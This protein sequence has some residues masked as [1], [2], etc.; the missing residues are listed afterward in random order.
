MSRPVSPYKQ[1]RDAFNVRGVPGAD[2]TDRRIPTS[3]VISKDRDGTDTDLTFSIPENVGTYTLGKFYFFI[4]PYPGPNNQ[5]AAQLLAQVGPTGLLQRFHLANLQLHA[6]ALPQPYWSA[7]FTHSGTGEDH[8]TNPTIE[9]DIE[10]SSVGSANYQ[11]AEQSQGIVVNVLDVAEA[12][13]RQARPAPIVL[14]SQDRTAQ[15]IDWGDAFADPEGWNL[16]VQPRSSQY[17][18][19]SDFDAAAHTFS[20]AATG[21]EPTSDYVDEYLT[22]SATDAATGAAAAEMWQG[23]SGTAPYVRTYRGGRRVSISIARTLPA[24]A[25]YDAASNTVTIPL[26]PTADGSQAGKA[27]DLGAYAASASR[28]IGASLSRSLSQTGLNGQPNTHYEQ[29][30]HWGAPGAPSR[31][32]GT[33][34]PIPAGDTIDLTLT[35]SSPAVNPDTPTGSLAA[36]ASLNIRL[37][38]QWQPTLTIAVSNRHDIPEGYDGT[39]NPLAVADITAQ[40]SGLPADLAADQQPTLHFSLAD[41]STTAGENSHYFQLDD[42]VVANGVRVEFV[43]PAQDRATTTDIA[44]A[45]VVRATG[46][47]QVADKQQTEDID[48][49]VVI[50][51]PAWSKSSY[52][53]SITDGAQPPIE[54]GTI[55]AVKS[56]S[57]YSLLY[58]LSTNTGDNHRLAG[59]TAMGGVVSFDGPA[60]PSIAVANRYEIAAQARQQSSDGSQSGWSDPIPITLRVNKAETDTVARNTAWLPP[61][62]LRRTIQVGAAHGFTL[63]HVDAAWTAPAG[64]TILWSGSLTDRG[65]RFLNFTEQSDADAQLIHIWGIHAPARSIGAASILTLGGTVRYPDGSTDPLPPIAVRVRVLPAAPTPSTWGLYRRQGDAAPYTYQQLSSLSA[66]VNEGEI[67]EPDDWTDPLYFSCTELANRQIQASFSHDPGNV[68]SIDA[69]SVANLRLHAGDTSDTPTRHLLITGDGTHLDFETQTRYASHL[70]ITSPA[71]TISGTA[72]GS[73]HADIPI[74]L[75]LG[76]VDE[77]PVFPSDYNPTTIDARVHGLAAPFELGNRWHDP[78]GRQLSYQVRSTNDA[79]VSFTL[80]GSAALPQYNSAGTASLQARAYDGSI[81]SDWETLQHYRI[82][83]D[84]LADVDFAWAA[85]P[86]AVAGQ[87]VTASLFEDAAVG[88]DIITGLYATATTSSQTATVGAITYAIE[89]FGDGLV[90]LPAGALTNAVCLWWYETEHLYLAGTIDQTTSPTSTALHAYSRLAERDTADDKTTHWAEMRDIVS[91]SASIGFAIGRS[92]PTDNY[93]VAEIADIDTPTLDTLT[94]SV[95]LAGSPS[96]VESWGDGASQRVYVSVG[97]TLQAYANSPTLARA[98]ADDITIPLSLADSI[99]AFGSDDT[100]AW[101]ACLKGTVKTLR[102]Y[103]KSDENRVSRFDV[104]LTMSGNVMS[105]EIVGDWIA[106]LTDAPAM[107][108]LR[109]PGT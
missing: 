103:R 25:S 11:P 36:T 78:E 44:A 32:T 51:P 45:V 93:I 30:L 82:T 21:T 48:V 74:S 76:D 17:W 55:E 18:T 2:A 107:F 56:N 72:Y 97:R 106:I 43:G 101:I 83:A 95:S 68:W 79:I 54:A 75:Q 41:A 14:R 15:Q 1:L 35:A 24:G 53:F 98:T 61:G 5:L 62:G 58:R 4:H 26:L 6:L 109:K 88:T 37:V 29:Y 91:P 23:S 16:E 86:A 90:S 85:P 102:C 67:L 108:V 94:N 52:S 13:T 81:Y 59:I 71:T 105:V 31:L 69:S 12:T 60:V 33:F 38:S 65:R 7:D 9:L 73:I 47:A 100:H 92:N 8:E 50:P 70:I 42:K 46:T 89:P 10:A 20:I 87:T 22:A 28:V 64:S 63:E 96:S 49:D 40:I 34:P 77:G 3:I 27:I 39:A 99:Q 66:L 104:P 57:D 84:T 80:T 19:I